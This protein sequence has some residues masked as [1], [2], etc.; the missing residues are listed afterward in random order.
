MAIAMIAD[1]VSRNSDFMWRL[2]ILSISPINRAI[3][4]LV[5]VPPFAGQRDTRLKKL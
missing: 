2:A 4:F 3:G 5:A 1:H